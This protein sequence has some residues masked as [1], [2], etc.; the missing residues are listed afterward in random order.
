MKMRK[1][2][3]ARTFAVCG[4]GGSLV[5]PVAFAL[6]CIAGHCLGQ[7]TVTITFDNP[8][9]PPGTYSYVNQ[10]S[11]S[12]MQFTAP[13]TM[14]DFVLVGSG[15][16]GVPNDGSTYLQT[17]VNSTVVLSSLSG[18]PFGLIAFDVAGLQPP[19][20][21]PHTASSRLPAGRRNGD[22]QFQQHY[23]QFPDLAAW[24]RIREPEHG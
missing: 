6:F 10:Y 9:Q 4:C 7:G 5:A 8:P 22:E 23:R 19:Y 18:V 3:T 12:G 16:A 21:P 20:T 13:G 11:E 17:L 15:L 24:L 2:H 1:A 14:D